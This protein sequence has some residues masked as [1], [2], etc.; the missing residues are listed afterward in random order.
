[1]DYVTRLMA[2]ARIALTGAVDDALKLNIFKVLD[3]F[4]RE[5]NIWQETIE[6]DTIAGTDIVYDLVPTLGTILRLMWVRQ[7]EAKAPSF[8]SMAIPGELILPNIYTP[9]THVYAT[10]S[11]APIDPTE[12]GTDL[13]VVADWLWQR[14]FPAF[15]DGL[16]LKMSIQPEKPYTNANLATYHGQRWRQALGIARAD[17]AKLNVADGQFWRFPQFAVQRNTTTQVN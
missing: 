7:G 3:E 14:Y 5:T 17:A 4:C 1:M 9:L 6:F 12:M 13:P 15:E 2:N 10:V 16:I 8:G 11:L